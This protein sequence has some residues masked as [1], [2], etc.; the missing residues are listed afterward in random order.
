MGV[1]LRLDKLAKYYVHLGPEELASRRLD[2]TSWKE[3]APT[4]KEIEAKL[5]SWPEP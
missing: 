4:L 2:S 1:A 5:K 3:T